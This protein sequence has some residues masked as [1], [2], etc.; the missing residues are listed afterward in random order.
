MG[1]GVGEFQ[2]WNLL[3]ICTPDSVYCFL[4]NAGA[5]LL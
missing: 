1:G 3:E 4:D 5:S 2:I